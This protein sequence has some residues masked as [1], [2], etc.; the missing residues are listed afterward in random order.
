V[1]GC[2]EYGN[3]PSV[4]IKYMEFLAW[5]VSMGEVKSSPGICDDYTRT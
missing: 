4:V 3:E 2:C 1:S 5:L